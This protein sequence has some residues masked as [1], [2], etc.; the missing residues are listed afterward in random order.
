[1]DIRLKWLFGI[2]LFVIVLGT[3]MQIGYNAYTNWKERLLNREGGIEK[4]ITLPDFSALC[5]RFKHR[6]VPKISLPGCILRE[7][8]NGKF[9]LVCEKENPI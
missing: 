4:C 6:P 2:V 7:G 9:I 3:A 1:M 5:G 8:L